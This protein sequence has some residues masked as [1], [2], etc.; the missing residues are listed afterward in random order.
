MRALNPLKI[1]LSALLF[2]SAL[3]PMSAVHAAKVNQVESI[4][5]G[6]VNEYAAPQSASVTRAPLQ[7]E[8]HLEKL[9]Q[10]NITYNSVPENEKPAIEAAVNIWAQYWKSSV[11]VNVSATFGRSA[12]SG[13]LA[14]ATPVKYFRNFTGT[15]DK[16]LYYPSAMANAIAGKDLDTR[17]P[18]LEIH[19]NSVMASALYLGT[20]G[21]CPAESYDLESIILHEMGHGL[22]FLSNDSYDPAFGYGSIDQPT[23]YDAYAQL[24]DGRRLMD[25]DS[26]SLELG[27]ALTTTLVWSGRNGIAANN[28]VKPLLYTPKPY[29]AG[30]SI[31]HLDER[32]F[33]AS[34]ENAVMTPNLASGEVFH[35]PGSI[36]VAMLQDMR[37]KPPAGV[38]TTAPNVPRNVHA[39]V[40]DKSAIVTWDSPTNFRTAQVSSYTVKVNQT[41]ATITSDMSPVTITGLKNGQTYSFTITATNAIGVSDPATTNAVVPQSSWVKSTVDAA[42]DAK[43]LAVSTF[44]SQ[45]II[46]YSDSVHGDLKLATYNGKKWAI[47]TV[48]GAGGAGGRTSHDVS[49]SVSLCIT[50]S[51]KKQILN[52]F[53]ADLTDKDLRYAS[54]DGKKWAFEVVDGNGPS[55]QD[56]KEP[57]RVRTASD[58]SVSSACVSTPDGL[59]V[60]Y[61]DESQGVLLGA[62]R[63]GKSWRYELIDGDR[64]TDGRTTGDVAFHLKATA[65]GKA[66][67]LLYDSTLKVNQDK[68]AIQGEIRQATRSSAYPED[69]VFTSPDPTGKS[70]TIAGYDIS[71]STS[72]NTINSAWLGSSG[73][74]IPN[75]DQVRWTTLGSTS[76]PTFAATESYGVPTAPIATNGQ[77]ILFGCGTRLCVMNTSDKKLS[78]VST[79]DFTSIQSV[80]WIVIK[81]VTYALVGADGKLS[82]FKAI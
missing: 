27:Q 34:G 14:S 80:Q 15:P 31:S 57:D 68:L 59:Q 38:A 72:G 64:T 69:W 67:Y 12:S 18:E 35:S 55:I 79:S 62:V 7:Q 5:A 32:S 10:F 11:P 19:I 77:R 42:A 49:G 51:G 61:R 39:L 16:D 78:L 36:L 28:G 54:Y 75:A 20:D 82:L 41:G 74:T 23:P 40:G 53:Y 71:L 50:A 48:D 66:V 46:A 37:E 24:P 6:W 81:G 13:V 43:N 52:L 25:L 17:N 63:S 56:Y 76:L 33:S 8:A 2:V 45:P 60:F 65:I 70:V 21:N 73:L 44:Q 4:A 26:P 58:V 22:G 30:S 9:S 29:E 1:G 47:V 3:S